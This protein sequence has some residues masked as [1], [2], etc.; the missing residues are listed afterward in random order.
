MTHLLP[1]GRVPWV[2]GARS[3]F[4]P[5]LRHFATPRSVCHLATVVAGA[6]PLR[7]SPDA[8]STWPPAPPGPGYWL[9]ASETPMCWCRGCLVVGLVRSILCHYCLGGCS[10]L[11]VCARRSRQA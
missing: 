3:P 7:R 4:P 1:G 10:A 11:V 5:R 9:V 2:H 8:W 6:Y